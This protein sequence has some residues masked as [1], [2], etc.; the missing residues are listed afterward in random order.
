MYINVR[1]FVLPKLFQTL[2]F[3]WRI[4]DKQLK[5]TNFSFA[6]VLL[7]YG[8]VELA[9]ILRITLPLA[10]RPDLTSLDECLVCEIHNGSKRFF[11]AFLYCSPSQSI[12]QFSFFKQRCEETIINISLNC[13]N[14][15][16][17]FNVLNIDERVKF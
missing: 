7:T 10:L 5:G 13:V 1:F 9:C 12:E 3:R 8:G 4:R 6:I 14:W 11:L 15:D 2:R 17:E 16:R